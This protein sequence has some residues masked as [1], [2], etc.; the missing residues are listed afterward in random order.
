VNIKKTR[1]ATLNI[2]EHSAYYISKKKKK[3]IQ[4]AQMYTDF[5]DGHV[6]YS[7]SILSKPEVFLLGKIAPQQQQQDV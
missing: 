1:K 3:L 4:H 6:M 7:I 5:V 2:N